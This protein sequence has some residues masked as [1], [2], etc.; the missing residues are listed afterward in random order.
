MMQRMRP[1]RLALQSLMLNPDNTVTFDENMLRWI[2]GTN[3]GD[4]NDVIDGLDDIKSGQNF[5]FSKA[6]IDGDGQANL[7]LGIS[8]TT[9]TY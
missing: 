4:G 6:D 9:N 8:K 2:G 7:S 3:A 5:G 1:G